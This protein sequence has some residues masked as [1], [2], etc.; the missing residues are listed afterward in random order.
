M[1]PG[2]LQ[3]GLVLACRS[4]LGPGMFPRA[5]KE[6]V[7]FNLQMGPT[8]PSRGLGSATKKE[9]WP[10]LPGPGLFLASQFWWQ[11]R[12][13]AFCI[14]GNGQ[15]LEVATRKPE[16]YQRQPR[17]YLCQQLADNLWV[18]LTIGGPRKEREGKE[19]SPRTML[20]EFLDQGF[21]AK[22]RPEG[23]GSG[24]VLSVVGTWIVT[25]YRMLSS[26]ITNGELL[27]GLK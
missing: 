13:A 3:D 19:G 27:K 17:P 12:W 6:L 11:L 7:L 10:S 20:E 9:G 18:T 24:S 5:A 4:P 8:V 23:W 26:T 25:A 21:R 15:H 22:L 14:T 2:W 16:K 1:W